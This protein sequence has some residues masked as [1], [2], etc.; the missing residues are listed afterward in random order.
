MKR[1]VKKKKRQD[2]KTRQS[3]L[4][5][6]TQ[7][8]TIL[9]HFQIEE[10]SWDA[11]IIGDGSGT[12]WDKS[13]GCASLLLEK[14][15]LEARPFFAGLSHGTN[16]V[17]EIL[18]ILQP[19]LYLKENRKLARNHG[20]RVIAFSDCQH[21]VETL[22]TLDLAK[23]QRAKA[24]RPLWMCLADLLRTGISLR[25]QHMPRNS[26]PAATFAHEAANQARRTMVGLHGTRLL[27]SAPHQLE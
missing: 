21:V 24:N 5:Q 23:A 3:A 22:N 12:T 4:Q 26:L 14:E 11:V 2:Q 16:I 8:H 25:A 15:A 9:D 13:A 17:A 10:E 6:V 20:Y 1:S 27:Q 18:A 19:L 7:I